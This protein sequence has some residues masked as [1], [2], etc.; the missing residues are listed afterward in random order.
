MNFKTLLLQSQLAYEKQPNQVGKIV[1]INLFT[2]GGQWMAEKMNIP[3][4]CSIPFNIYGFLKYAVCLSAFITSFLFFFDINILLTPFS[5]LVFYFFEIH[6]LFLFPLLID[7][8][9]FPLWKSIEITYKIGIFKAMFRVIRIAIFMLLGILNFKNPF[10]NWH[11]G[12]LFILIW[13]KNEVRN[14][15]SI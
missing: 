3:I 6:F 11:I 9:P 1:S 12:C 4:D 8:I 14:R 7:K 2:E 10:K 5:V 13:Y 15:L